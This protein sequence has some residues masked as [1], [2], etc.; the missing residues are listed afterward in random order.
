MR[1]AASIGAPAAGSL[2]PRRANNPRQRSP[3]D[4][5]AETLQATAGRQD[6]IRLEVMFIRTAVLIEILLDRRG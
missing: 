5:W 4:F 1:A 2:Y 6:A 3:I